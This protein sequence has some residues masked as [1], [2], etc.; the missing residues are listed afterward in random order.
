MNGATKLLASLTG[1]AAGTYAAGLRWVNGGHRDGEPPLV[2]GSLPYLGTALPFGRDATSFLQ[3]CRREHGDVFTLFVAGRRMTFVCDPRS[4]PA[5]LRN[6]AL[7][8]E[9]FVDQ[10]L[11]RSFDLPNAHQQY[12]VAGSEVLARKHLRGKDLGDLSERMSIE[13]HRV[14][15]RMLDERLAGD[16]GEVDLYRLVRDV[17]FGAGTQVVFGEGIACPHFARAFEDFDEQ[18][19]A[20]VAGVPKVMTRRG[21]GALRVLAD[22]L[23]ELGRAPSQ[24]MRVRAPLLEAMTPPL[25]GRAQATVLWALHANTIPAAFW[26]LAHVLADA[27]ASAAVGRELSHVLGDHDGPLARDRIDALV[28]IDGAA[29]EALRLSAGSLTVRRAVEPVTLQLRS[30]TWSLR[31]GDEVCLAPQVT[32]H[33]PSVFEQPEHFVFD[34]FAAD[35]PGH[36]ARE[37][38]GEPSAFS[39]MPF[40][41]GKHLCPG[42]FFALNEIKIVVA[43]LLGRLRL[44]PITEPLPQY[45]RRRVGLGV[46]TPKHD[47]RVRWSRP[48]AR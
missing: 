41:A 5:V 22:S 2:P 42:R 46:F 4:Y 12:D 19:P 13:V 48:S 8:F 7:Q 15:D 11:A 28:V 20:L 37:H 25:R 38:D 47:L 9:P 34:R 1:A 6:P 33:D 24:W 29:R 43:A 3:Q 14:L 21:R 36:G 18:L 17:V 44:G 39:F 31:A 30:G 26:T 40:G 35:G 16:G 23:A 10:F 27:E 32:H 45:D